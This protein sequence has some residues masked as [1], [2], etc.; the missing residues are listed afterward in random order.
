MKYF[1]LAWVF[2]ANTSIA[3]TVVHPRAHAHNDYEHA[4]PLK[5][6]LQNGF[7]SV[8]AD[9][10]LKNGKLLVGHNKVTETS[11]SLEHLYLKPLDSLLTAHK[12]FVYPSS[13]ATFFLMIDIKTNGDTAYS[14]LKKLVDRYPK[15]KCASDG[16]AV[17]IFL[18]GNRPVET[19]LKEGYQ[20]M[21][22]DGRPENLGQHVST[23]LMP[24]IS[25]TYYNWSRWNGKQPPAANDLARIRE[26]ATSVHAEGKKLRLWAT[27]DNEIAWRALL[28]AGVDLINTD[29]LKELN[30]FLKE[31]EGNFRK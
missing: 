15:L 26:L 20:G 29:R 19:I 14:F 13:K 9:V 3:Q 7:L 16:C 25:D 18:S 4:R 5:D 27:P 30:E 17:S 1:L 8:E 2:V 22:L 6:A 24:V 28:D 31:H 12:G 10:H 11:P 21:A 23:Q